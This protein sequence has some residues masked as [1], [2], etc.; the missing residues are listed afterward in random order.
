MYI[1]IVI[2]RENIKNILRTGQHDTVIWR[3]NAYPIKWIGVVCS[4]EMVEW[5]IR[6][7]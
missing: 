2:K 4:L 7:K 5:H 6:V 1:T 3:G